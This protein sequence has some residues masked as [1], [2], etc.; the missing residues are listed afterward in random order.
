MRLISRNQ[1]EL[2]AEFPEIGE[3]PSRV[4]AKQA[5][6]DGEICALDQEGRPSFSLMQQRT[7]FE[8][9]KGPRRSKSP[10]ISGQIT[11]VYYVFDLLYLEGYSLLRVD[12]E[13][14]KE[15]LKSILDTNETIHYS[16]HFIGNGTA[17][18]EAAKQKGLEGI[19]AKR[20]KGC[21][22]QKR[23]REWLKIKITQTQDCVIGGYT[24]PRGSREYFGS[25]VLGLY[26]DQD[27]LIPVGQAGS[28]FTQKSQAE[29][30]KLLKKIEANKSPFY[31]KP[32]SSRGLH[33]LRPELVAEIRFT[34]WTHAG[35]KGGL[36]MRAPVFVGIR[37]D[38][39]PEECRFELKKSAKEEIAKAEKGK[40]A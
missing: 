18:L 36:K 30:W 25:L 13:K 2:T 15:L 27:R 21:Y 17:L 31:T 24:E 9:G 26:D 23:S 14:R 7:G 11:I 35:Q 33:Y 12:L 4:G 8:P 37:F 19:V 34:E 38:K 40:A 28:G 1:N 29:V 6:L 22:E 39:K 3:L 16:D 10:N 5:I 20:R 32:D